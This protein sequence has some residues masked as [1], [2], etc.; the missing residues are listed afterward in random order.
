MLFEPMVGRCG[1]LIADTTV[2]CK[3]SSRKNDAIEV[4]TVDVSTGE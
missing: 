4:E 1:R 2:D 3:D